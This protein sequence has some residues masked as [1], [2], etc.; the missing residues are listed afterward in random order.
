MRLIGP[1]T[2]AEAGVDGNG[3]T[4]SPQARPG[5]GLAGPDAAVGPSSS[6]ELV[7]RGWDWS[8]GRHKVAFSLVRE[9][10]EGLEAHLALGDIQLAQ[11]QEELTRSGA[12]FHAALEA[13]RLEDAALQATRKEATR[14]AK[15]VREGAIRDA[16]EL[17]EPLQA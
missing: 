6:Q 14:F 4:F 2:E 15:E 13:R 12:S 7:L 11:Q 17:L 8:A 16:A 10:L 5:A 9:S 3:A 1:S